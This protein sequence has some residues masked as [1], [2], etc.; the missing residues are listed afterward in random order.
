MYIPIYC[1]LTTLSKSYG[2]IYPN[3]VFSEINWYSD[4]SS[5]LSKNRLAM[6]QFW[7]SDAKHGARSHALFSLY[8]LAINAFLTRKSSYII[9]ELW[10]IALRKQAKS[11]SVHFCD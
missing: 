3:F 11:V 2:S 5:P 6:T 4:K 9:P 7:S 8:S 10:A 1:I